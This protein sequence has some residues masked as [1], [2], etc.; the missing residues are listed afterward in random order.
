MGDE[1][2]RSTAPIVRALPLV[3]SLLCLTLLGATSPALASGFAVNDQGARAQGLGGAFTG[4]ADDATAV[5]YNPGGIALM[6]GGGAAGG[7]TLLRR[8]ESLFQGL[9]P[10]LGSGAN[11]QQGTSLDPLPH[12]YVVKPLKPWLK[13]GIALNTPFFFSSSWQGADSFP[14]RTISL[15][16]DLSTYDA[17]TVVSLK[18]GSKVGFGGG[19]V[20]RTSSLTESHRLQLFNPLADADVDVASVRFKTD[21]ENEL[22]WTA[23]LLHRVSKGFSWGLSYRSKIATSYSGTGQLT[24]V[25]TGDDQFDALVAASL[26]LGQDLAMTTAL[27][28]PDELTLGI[29]VGLGKSLRLVTDIQ[30]TGWSSV[31]RLAFHLA[32]EPTFDQTFE[33]RLEDAMSFRAGLEL[34]LPSGLQLRLGAAMEG[35]TQPDETVGPL[36]ADADRTVITGGLGL[37]WLQVGVSYTEV[38]DRTTRTNLDDL[39]GTYRTNFWSLAITI[40]P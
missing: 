3:L 33:L 32:D 7:L 9:S 31:D 37:D 6:E 40:A 39:N 11:G 38:A 8:N 24:Q 25:P 4:L 34:T 26:P 23:G 36:L 28:L 22:G 27:E 13:L 29:A 20:L 1:R 14:G 15:K 12:V 2:V 19:V 21:T 5:F 16:S 17:T 18:L 10:G 30:R 35:N